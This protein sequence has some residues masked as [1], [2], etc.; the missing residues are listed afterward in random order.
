MEIIAA[1]PDALV[2]ASLCVSAV[3]TLTRHEPD[4]ATEWYDLA[5]ALKRH[6][7]ILRNNI[8]GKR[9]SGGGG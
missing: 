7:Q 8:D 5:T 2:P 6:L 9:S 4:G 3:D 1:N